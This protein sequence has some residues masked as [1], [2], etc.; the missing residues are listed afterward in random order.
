MSYSERYRIEFKN[1]YNVNSVISI[2]ELDYSGTVTEL[3]AGSSNPVLRKDVDGHFMGTSLTFYVEAEDVDGM[4]QFYTENPRKFKVKYYRDNTLVFVGFLVPEQYSDPYIYPPFDIELEAVDGIGLLKNINFD[5]FG[6]NKEIDIIDH[7]LKKTGFEFDIAI[8]VNIQHELQSNSR[9]ALEY[10]SINVNQFYSS[11]GEAPACYDVLDKILGSYG[12][13]IYLSRIGEKWIIFRKVDMFGNYFVYRDATYISTANLMSIVDYNNTSFFVVNSFNRSLDKRLHNVFLSVDLGRVNSILPDDLFKKVYHSGSGVYAKYI[14]EN[15]NTV[16]DASQSDVSRAYTDADADGVS[17]YFP[18]NTDNYSNYLSYHFTKEL[19]Q[20]DDDWKLSFVLKIID[21]G[22]YSTRDIAVP[23]DVVFHGNNI[24]TR[25][26][27]ESG[28]SSTQEPLKATLHLVSIGRINT[29]LP[30]QSIEVIIDSLP[31][32]GTIEFRFYR[33]QDSYTNYGFA[34]NVKDMTFGPNV[35]TSDIPAFTNCDLTIM[36]P[37]INTESIEGIIGSAPDYPNKDV[38]YKKVK[39]DVSGETAIVGWKQ[40]NDTEYSSLIEILTREIASN[41][42]GP[43][44]ILSGTLNG[45][46]LNLFTAFKDKTTANEPIFFLYSGEWDLYEDE[47]SGTWKEYFDFQEQSFQYILSENFSS[48]NSDPITSSTVGGGSGSA[49]SAIS[50][51]SINGKPS[52]F[53]PEPHGHSIEEI[54]IFSGKFYMNENGDFVFNTNIYVYGDVIQEGSA[55][56]T[57]AEQV[58][59]TKDFIIQ[60]EGAVSAIA[61]GAIAGSKI[62]KADG[63]NNVIFGT[64][65]DAVA[66]IGWEGGALQAIATREDNPTSNGIAH[67]D[68]TLNMFVAKAK[69]ADADKLD[70]LD[71]S[72]FLRSDVD[73]I[74]TG[75]LKFTN[76]FTAKGHVFLYAIEGEGNSGTAYLQARDNS[77]TSNIDLQLRTQNA[78]NLVNVMKLTSGGRVGIGTTL[79]SAALHISNGL[80]AGQ[81][82]L[83]RPGG[84]PSMQMTNGTTEI[85]AIGYDNGNVYLLGTDKL[86]VLSNGNVGIGTKSPSEKLD[87]NGNGK[88]SGKGLFGS[89]I[90]QSS[91]TIGTDNFA[92][93]TRGWRGTYSGEF[94]V[95]YLYA[96]ELHVQAF[97]ADVS[98]ALAGSDFLTKSVAKLAADFIVPFTA[99]E[100]QMIVEDLPG[101]EGIRCFEENDRIRV[102]VLDRSEGGLIVRDV[103]GYVTLDTSYGINGFANDN[104]QAYIFHTG[105]VHAAAENKKVNKGSIVLDYGKSGDGFIERTVLDQQGSPYSQV[106][107]WTGDPIMGSMNY[108]VLTRWGVLDGMQYASGS[109]LYG[110]R[111]FLTEYLLAG[112]LTKA[113]NYLEY[114]NGV[115]NIDAEEFNLKA[116]NDYWRTADNKFR[117]GGVNGITYDGSQVMIGSDVLVNG[118]DIAVNSLPAIS[119]EGLI[120]LWRFDEG[121]GNVAINSAGEAHGTIYGASYVQGISGYGLEFGGIGSDDRVTGLSMGNPQK[122]TISFWINAYSLDYDSNNNYRHILYAGVNFVIFEENGKIT[123]RVPGVYTIGDFRTNPLNINTLYHITLIYDQSDMIIYVN[124]QEVNRRNIGSGTVSVDNFSISASGGHCFHGLIDELRIYN[125]A[126][127]EREIKSLYLHP[128]GNA[129]GHISANQVRTGELISSNWD[130]SKGTR[131]DL[132]A[133]LLEMKYGGNTIFK[134]DSE[135]SQAKIAGVNFNDEKLWTTR[136]ELNKDGSFSFGDGKITGDA[137]GNIAIDGSLIAL[138]LTGQILKSSNWDDTNR[139]GTLFDLNSGILEMGFGGNTIFKLDSTSEVAEIGGFTINADSLSTTGVNGKILVEQDGGRFLRINESTYAP[140]LCVRSDNGEAIRIYT[141]GYS[142]VGLSGFGQT[143]STLVDLYGNMNFTARSSESINFKGK[144]NIDKLILNPY[145][146]ST[147]SSSS[148]S[149]TTINTSEYG[150]ALVWNPYGNGYITLTDGEDG[151]LFVVVATDDSRNVYV[152]TTNVIPG[153]DWYEV[154]GGGVLVLMWINYLQNP[155]RGGWLRVSAIDNNW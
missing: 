137:A 101:Q 72:Q 15:W 116:G 57:H 95:R 155:P 31:D 47:I 16:G 3:N 136:W 45:S 24:G 98:Q 135:N 12:N 115:L 110:R 120:G 105:E 20:T 106:V 11:D 81:L 75:K 63:T 143:G 2:E 17:C 22:Y 109:G 54:S 142:G 117:F 103:W 102:R 80:W 27:T 56:E 13:E 119:D 144:V 10:T 28:W 85:T 125:R 154:N 44:Q 78:G 148:T 19:S 53:P 62:L 46:Q 5:L 6:I 83:E 111:T 122:F 14:C 134:F 153:G 123:F 86:K 68:S 92:S 66:R 152:S 38:F 97:T 107:R 138:E 140:V 99:T 74:A 43:I 1:K 127:T 52:T 93:Q 32:D 96:D 79:P 141:Q 108:D 60:R 145:K 29:V 100:N 121:E 7:I 87:V 51:D 23:F 113:T 67:W 126:L 21:A 8:A 55:Y 49:I 94:D 133:G 104:T 37:P 36:D 41:N 91:G 90:I 132:N 35:D 34:I 139:N 65:A 30:E 149:P 88:F 146:S 70:G 131:F 76:D 69:A 89:D 26:L 48:D 118:A 40:N 58:Y 84:N 82:K 64:G 18:K 112:D 128:S 71:S 73:D 151:Q 129:G 25:Y 150:S 147:I 42:R 124:S 114:D 61:T 77:G 4:P 9:P 130:G 50:W 59:T 33:N 39:F